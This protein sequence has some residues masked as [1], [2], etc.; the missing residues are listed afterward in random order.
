MNL[1]IL[2][3]DQK[4]FL[5][6]LKLFNRSFYLVGGTAIALQ[7]GHRESIDFDLFTRKE[8]LNYD[9][10]SDKIKKSNNVVQTVFTRKSFCYTLVINNVQFTFYSYLYDVPLNES[11]ENYIKMPDLLTLAAMK[12]FALGKRAKWK[13]YVDLYFILTKYHTLKEISLKA[14]EIF[15]GEFNDK[16]FRISLSYFEDVDYTEKVNYKNNS[17]VED[18]LI[19]KHFK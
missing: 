16:N 15:K 12:A 9:L 14:K 4:D 10:I 18:A 17:E 3:S 8:P 7:I 6:L 5:P 1:N 11:F 13:D 19:K 2:N